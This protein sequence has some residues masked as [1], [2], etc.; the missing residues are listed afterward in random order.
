MSNGL[1]ELLN[2]IGNEDIKYQNIRNDLTD[3]VQGK[4][5]LSYVTFGT[6]EFSPNDLVSNNGKVGLVVWIDSEK[7]KAAMEKISNN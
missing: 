7:V 1:V 4:N 3:I 5:N 2:E 6:T